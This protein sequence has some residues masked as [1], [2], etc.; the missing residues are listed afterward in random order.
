MSTKPSRI[1]L[2]KEAGITIQLINGG[3]TQTITIDGTSVTIE[4]KGPMGRST[5]V[6]DQNQV[7]IDCDNFMV[8]S[9][10]IMCSASMSAMIES[11]P[12]VLELSPANASLT[13]PEVSLNAE[14][15]VNIEAGA[16]CTVTA[17]AGATVTAGA[18]VA[19]TGATVAITGATSTEMEAPIMTFMGVPDFDGI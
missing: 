7:R 4:V 5:Y 12:S 19:I 3:I 6:Q 11:G 14:A 15:A 1:E 16:A 13:A 9:K 2:D 8:R 17:G 18:A 10:T